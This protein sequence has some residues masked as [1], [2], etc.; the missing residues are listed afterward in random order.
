[1]SESSVFAGTPPLDSETWRALL[2]STYG[3]EMTVGEPSTFA[4]W[5]HS[6]SACGFLASAIRIEC[7][8]RG[9]DPDRNAYRAERTQR[10]VRRAGLDHYVA[11]FQGAGRTAVIQNGQVVELAAGDVGLEDT[12]R[13]LTLVSSGYSERRVLVLPRQSLISHIGFEPQGGFLARSGTTRLLHQLLRDA[14]DEEELLAA[15][16]RSYMQMAVYDLLGALL[17]GS[18]PFLRYNTDN[19]FARIC[20]IIRERFADPDFG[21]GEAAA[22]AG[23]SLRYLQ[24]LFTERGSTCIHY[25]H[26]LRLDHAARLLQRRVSLRTGQPLSEIAYACGFNDYSYFV[27]KFRQRFGYPPSATPE[28]SARKGP[29]LEP[30]KRHDITGP[31]TREVTPVQQTI[32]GK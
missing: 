26:A 6:F 10:D 27:R 20:G 29:T 16:A 18:D 9:F 11:L 21:P 23:I 22:E 25:I 13:P 12:S 8:S 5:W 24:K 4:G 14:I 7:G 15:P 17:A 19:L 1:M 31:I 2:R 3:T 30:V 32:D 28:C